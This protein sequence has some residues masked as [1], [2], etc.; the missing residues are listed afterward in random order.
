MTAPA[1]VYVVIGTRPEAIKLAPVVLALRECGIEY[2]ILLTGQHPAEVCDPI[3]AWF[4]ISW[5]GRVRTYL[6]EQPARTLLG[7]AGR[8][9]S[10]L[11]P[12]IEDDTCHR[13]SLLIVQGDTT[14]AWAGATAGFLAGIPVMHVEAGLR[15]GDRLSPYPEE[16]NRVQI[17]QAATYHAAP[18]QEAVTAL[19]GE[20][21]D[22]DK[23][24]VT[25][26]TVVDALWYTLAMA[27]RQSRNG[28][29][30]VLVTMHRRESHGDPMRHICGQLREL[31][32]MHKDVEL[33]LPMHPNP[34]VRDVVKVLNHDRIRMV[35]PLSYPNFVSTLNTADL[36]L[37]DSGGVQ[38]EAAVLGI[39]CVV[40]REE[41]DRPGPAIV[42]GTDRVYATASRLLSDESELAGLRNAPNPYGD[43]AASER[44]ADWV[45]EVLK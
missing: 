11:Q 1:T 22:Y 3:L 20:G 6:R 29:R 34:A 37:T 19:H 25:G 41:S 36:V 26:N 5:E 14:S 15:T 40:M 12:Y 27:D 38:E 30:R 24:R 28:H 17:A 9:L 18:T 35:E 2:T 10:S 7:S 21:V 16:F 31:V 8:C 44:I 33:I 32:N 39:P 42:A 23:I 13:P 43:G 4:G 45:A